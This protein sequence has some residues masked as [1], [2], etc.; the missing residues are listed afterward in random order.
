[1]IVSLTCS[2]C[3]SKRQKTLVYQYT[4]V[5]VLGDLPGATQ[6][7]LMFGFSFAAAL[8]SPMTAALL[9]QYGET[10]GE[11]IWPKVLAAETCTRHV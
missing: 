9:A 1:M 11:P 3:F 5:V 10:P 2:C 6:L 7:I 8:E 4:L